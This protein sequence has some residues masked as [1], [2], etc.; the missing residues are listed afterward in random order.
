MKVPVTS[1]IAIIVYALCIAMF[2][3]SHLMKAD[4]MAEMIQ[5]PG[6]ATMVYVTGVCLL[7]AA[8]AFILNKM[9][10]TA[11]YLLA[12]FL[13]LTATMVHLKSY[14][15]GNEMSMSQMLKD[16]AMAAGAILIANVEES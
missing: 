10:K 4:A 7:A 9:R 6:G 16:F 13:I 1:R 11:A 14:M 5:P 8:L 2:G 12:L 3:I 15:A